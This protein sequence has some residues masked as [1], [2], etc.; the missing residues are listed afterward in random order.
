VYTPEERGALAERVAALLREDDRIEETMLV[1]AP[2]TEGMIA[3]LRRGDAELAE[4]LEKP[5][6]EFVRLR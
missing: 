1:A 6:L 2:A 5:L 3:E 4:K